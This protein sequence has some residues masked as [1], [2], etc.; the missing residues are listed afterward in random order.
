[1]LRL[2]ATGTGIYI[3]DLDPGWGESAY[4]VVQMAG[5][6]G[7]IAT[8]L[9]GLAGWLLATAILGARRRLPGL[10]AIG[11]PAAV[12]IALLAFDVIVPDAELADFVFP[13]YVFS[14]TIGLPLGLIGLAAT[15]LVPAGSR[16]LAVSGQIA[17]S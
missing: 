2:S 7:L 3:A 12:I 6:Q 14:L 5:T 8:G 15:L 9:L 1:M 17:L 16:R 10:L 11:V 13:I 4:I